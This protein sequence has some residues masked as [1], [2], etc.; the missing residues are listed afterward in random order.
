MITFPNAKINLG[1]HITGLRPDGYHEIETIFYPVSIRDALEVI[2]SETTKLNVSGTV[3][4]ECRN[5]DNLVMKAYRLM[6][7]NYAFV[8]PVDIYLKKAIP[9]GAGLGGGSSD[10]A[11]MLKLINDLYECGATSDE[12]EEIAATIGADCPFFIRNKPVLATGMGNIFEST[13]VSLKGRCLCLVK[14]P[15]TV[16]TKEAYAG[17]TPRNPSFRLSELP[18]LPVCEWR[19]VLKN[20]FEETVFRRYPEIG[21]IKAKLYSLGAEYAAMSGS[22]SAV[23]GIFA[24]STESDF[25]TIFPDYFVWKGMSD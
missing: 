6:A 10:A 3:S 8:R 13:A 17:T 11:F 18:L 24:A 15:F 14:P 19:N 7:A 23:F 12:L 20:D 16:S 1:L 9:S 2:E 5:D 25:A 21:E 22:G 4:L